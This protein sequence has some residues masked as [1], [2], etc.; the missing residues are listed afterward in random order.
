MSCEKGF[1]RVKKVRQEENAV[2]FITNTRCCQS[3]A[4]KVGTASGVSHC[5]VQKP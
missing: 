5:A 2:S 4:Y 1:G 3:G